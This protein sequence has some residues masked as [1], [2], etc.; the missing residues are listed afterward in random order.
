MSLM[1]GKNSYLSH[2]APVVV[3][4]AATEDQNRPVRRHFLPGLPVAHEQKFLSDVLFLL[5]KQHL[6]IHYSVLGS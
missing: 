1:L 3:T 6:G 5:H 2:R 4:D